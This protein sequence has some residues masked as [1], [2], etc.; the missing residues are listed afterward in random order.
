[1]KILNL[2]SL[3]VSNNN[4]MKCVHI[5]DIG[6]NCPSF[7]FFW[8]L[9]YTFFLRLRL[10]SLFFSFPSFPFFFV[11]LCVVIAASFTVKRYSHTV[12]MSGFILQIDS[13][14]LLKVRKTRKMEKRE[15]KQRMGEK[16]NSIGSSSR[17]RTAVKSN[18]SN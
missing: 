11:M 3:P 1:M 17:S 9:I 18:Q 10:I 13:I 12:T 16:W 6:L 2:C 4:R 7:S 15:W 8:Y 14:N 5:V